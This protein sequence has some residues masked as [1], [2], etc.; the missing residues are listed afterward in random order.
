MTARPFL[1]WLAG[2]LLAIGGLGWQLR[3]GLP[4]QTDILALLPADEQDPVVAE[5]L[6][7]VSGKASRETLFLVTAPTWAEAAAAA[8]ALQDSLANSG[9]FAIPFNAADEPSLQAFY[10]LYFPRRWQLLTRPAR[11]QLGDGHYQDF[12]NGALTRL[13]SPLAMVSSE[14]IVADPLL[15]FSAFSESLASGNR[16]TL[17]DGWI[18]LPANDSERIVIRGRT[19]QAPFQ[20][21]FQE[22][23]AS[24]WPRASHEL[25]AAHGSANVQITGVLPFAAEASSQAKQEISTIGLGS[26]LGIV[27]LLLLTFRSP[28][29]LLLCLLPVASGM[30]LAVL[31]SLLIF[32]QLHLFTLVIGT[33]LIGV[34]IDYAFHYLAARHDAGADWRADRGLRAILPGISFGLVT[35]L[36]GYAALYFSAFPGLYQ[37]AT[38]SCIG[39]IGAWLTVVLAFPWLQQRALARPGRAGS[40]WLQA[41]CLWWQ[42]IADK[43]FAVIA[44]VLVLA[45]LLLGLGRLTVNDDIRLLQ[46]AS[47]ALLQADANIRE[48]TGTGTGNRFF[49]VAGGSTEQL[50]QREEALVDLLTEQQQLGNLEAVQ[51]SSRWLPSLARQRENRDWLATALEQ[52]AVTE[53]LDGLGLSSAQRRQLEASLQKGPDLTDEIF[54]ASPIAK[55]LE[56]LW[57]GSVRQQQVS[58]VLPSGVRNWPALQQAAAELDGVRAVDRVGQLSG[59]LGQYRERA[60][61]LVALAYGVIFILLLVRYGLT[62]AVRV[63][64]GPVLAALLAV[65]VIGWL[66]E[67]FNLFHAVALVLV[68]GIGIDY[69]I[70]FAEGQNHLRATALAITLSATSTLLA[71]GLLALSGTPAIH[72]FGLIILA[73]IAFA[74]L[75]API[76]VSAR[77]PQSGVNYNEF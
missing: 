8:S 22:A 28:S 58:V 77:S 40:R 11:Q 13:S 57:L 5:A 64:A 44:V 38:F 41:Y 23:F 53:Y 62:G 29:P 12:V 42:K 14:V 10:E 31:L 63:I 61:L 6:E 30:V 73:G 68:L 25:S 65:A 26:L 17:R 43:R 35:S 46:G 70:F 51:A 33:S 74:F 59:L 52:P 9:L 18:S 56:D 15:L 27:L 45:G 34:S 69:T 50:L 3:D 72:G 37:V 2:L 16:F 54:L 47:P 32:E 24:Y 4:I 48:A 55:P 1:Y 67:A 36:L 71:F 19:L 20:V 75:L 39:L 66:G 49:L 76:A 7:R 21:A 60:L